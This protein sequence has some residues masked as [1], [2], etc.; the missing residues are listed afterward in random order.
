[1]SPSFRVKMFKLHTET[2]NSCKSV[3]SS[4]PSWSLYD[5]EE[6]MVFG[7]AGCYSARPCC[8]W[9]HELRPKKHSVSVAMPPAPVR[10]S[11]QRPFFQS[12]A[13]VTSVAIDKGD[14]AMIMGAVHR[15]HG[16]CLTA[17]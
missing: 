5:P 2:F 4:H 11:S 14:N 6:V 16:I 12:V 9:S 8:P 10:V 17:E 1:M 3:L 15:S 7:L 13:S